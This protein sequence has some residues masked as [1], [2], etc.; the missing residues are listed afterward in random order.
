MTKDEALAQQEFVGRFAKFTDG[1]WREVTD[2]SAGVPL[3]TNP[4]Q[5]D[6]PPYAWVTFTPYGDEDDVWYENPEGQLL[7][8]WTYKPLYDTTPPQ[9]EFVGLTNKEFAEILCD[10]RWQGRPELMMLQVQAK[11]KDKNTK[12][13]E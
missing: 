1:I 10:D 2:G 13:Q 6:I 3:Y 9:R 5:P 4:P 11:L 8:G 7:E 12:G